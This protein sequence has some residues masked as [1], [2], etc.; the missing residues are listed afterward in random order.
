MFI[1]YRGDKILQDGIVGS[2]IKITK[3]HQYSRQILKKFVEEHGEKPHKISKTSVNSELRNF[4]E[5]T[6]NIGVNLEWLE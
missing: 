5:L 1:C 6:N 3:E 4:G 2:L